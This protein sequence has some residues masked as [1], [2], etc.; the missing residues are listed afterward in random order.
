M[1]GIAVNTINMK[2][3]QGTIQRILADNHSVIPNAEITY[4]GWLTKEATKKKNSSIVVEFTKPEP[5]NNIIYAGFLWEGLVHTC[6]LYDRSC[7][8][9]QCFRCYQY[10]HIGT[11]CSAPQACGHC[12][13]GH[14][15]KDCP[16]KSSTAE[17]V[18]KCAICKGSHTAWSPACPAKQKELQRVERAKLE[19][20]HYWP[21]Q[22]HRREARVSDP[23][24]RE[25]DVPHASTASSAIHRQPSQTLQARPPRGNRNRPDSSLPRE[26]RH[27]DMQEQILPLQTQPSTFQTINFTST[28]HNDTSAPANTSNSFNPDTWLQ[29]LQLDAD[30]ISSIDPNL[31]THQTVAQTPALSTIPDIAITPSDLLA[32]RP[33]CRCDD[34]RHLYDGWPARDAELI[35]GTCMRQCMYC[36]RSFNLPSVLRRHLQQGHSDLNLRIRKERKGPCRVVPAWRPLLGTVFPDTQ[37]TIAVAQHEL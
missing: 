36:N 25:G 16:A 15:S 19:R 10:G 6:Q 17:F 21:I 1:N 8:V 13:R 22:N 5:A 20:H 33:G 35:I 11:Q 32:I 4:V 27:Q 28:T 34:H 9:K 18:P 3:Q 14:Q 26:E 23:G 29:D 31:V 2:D 24:A 30:W 37:S 7:R 12:A